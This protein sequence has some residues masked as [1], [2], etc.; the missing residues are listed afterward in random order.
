MMGNIQ[1]VLGRYPNKKKNTPFSGVFQAV[2][3]GV[4]LT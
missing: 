2:P 1:E 3:T 4:N